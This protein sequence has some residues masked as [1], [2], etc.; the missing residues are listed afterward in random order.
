VS[1]ELIHRISIYVEYSELGAGRVN[2]FLTI[3]HEDNE[4]TFDIS[5]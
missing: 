5:M 1:R 3:E 4:S 2:F